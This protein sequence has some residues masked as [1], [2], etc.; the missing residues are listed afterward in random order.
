MGDLF[1]S[2]PTQQ[3]TTFTPNQDQQS[4][5]DMAMP[6][7]KQF[8]QQGIQQQ[9]GSNVAGWDPAQLQ[10]Q[11]M[12]LNTAMGSQTNLAGKTAG[13]ANFMLGDVLDPASNP[14]LQRYIQS[15]T[16]PI[17]D[18][19]MQSTLPEIRGEAISTGNF[20]GSGRGIAEGL[21]SAGASRAVGDTTAGIVNDAY[22]KGLNAVSSTLGQMPQIQASQLNPAQTVSSVGD[23]RQGMAQTLLDELRNQFMAKQM[24]PYQVGSLLLNAMQ[25]IPG[26]TSMAQG[27][28]GDPSPLMQG[29]GIGTILMGL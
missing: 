7:L 13:A 25:G 24:M 26:G 2:S 23:A 10:A 9:Q 5:I 3:T 17:T 1:K 11:Q 27:S 22:G 21:A 20:S 8:G 28:G 4:L 14:G 19:L 6:Y 18:Q 12:A 15:A 29:A 16:Q